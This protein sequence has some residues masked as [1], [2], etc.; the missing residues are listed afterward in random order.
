MKRTIPV[1]ILSLLIA[2]CSTMP[3]EIE[4]RYLAEK[5]ESE[6]KTIYSLEQKI[7]DT[8]REKETVEKK[9]KTSSGLP[10]GTEEEIKLLE[11]EN[12]LLK[13]QVYFYEKNKDAVNLE[14]KKKQLAENETRLAM[15]TA[16]L[17]Y[18][19]NEKKLFESELELKNAM[20]AEAIAELNVEKSKIA[21]TYRDKNEP[22]KPEQEEGFISGLYNRLFKRYDPNDKYGYG[23]NTDYLELKKKETAK[24]QI[25]YNEALKK[26][27]E[28]KGLLEKQSKN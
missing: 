5:T 23:K 19:L 2:G 18:Q 24:S 17:Q 22:Q 12:E 9:L 8:N 6:T 10:A 11:K 4:D 3:K 26:F 25:E 7:I 20:L 15:K 21:E 13:E 16:L 28:A 27:Q 14:S 1:L